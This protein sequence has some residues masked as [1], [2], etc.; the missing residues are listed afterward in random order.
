MASASH[1]DVNMEKR[2]F[3][4]QPAKV[5]RRQ[6][7]LLLALAADINALDIRESSILHSACYFG[8]E[9]IVEQTYMD[10]EKQLNLTLSF[11]GGLSLGLDIENCTPR[12]L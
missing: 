11:S 5:S 3:T 7:K 2:L 6:I 12:C 10:N 9:S 1:P 4:S 8:Y